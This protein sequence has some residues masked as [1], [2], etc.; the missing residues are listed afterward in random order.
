MPDPRQLLDRFHRTL[1]EEIRATRPEY[2]RLPFTVAEIYQNLIPYRTHRD[3]IGV[4]INGD[5]EDALLRLLVGEGDYLRLESEAA[6]KRIEAE[7]RSPNPNTTIYR[8]FA[9]AEVR[10]NPSRIPA[11]LGNGEGG[12]RVGQEAPPVPRDGG[13]R[14]NPDLGLFVADLFGDGGGRGEP[15]RAPASPREARPSPPAPDALRVAAA[16][17]PPS[18]LPSQGVAS[19]GSGAPAPLPESAPVP[20]EGGVHA[21]PRVTGRTDA[22][23]PPASKG[24]APTPEV[25]RLTEEN[26]RLRRIVADQALELQRLR[27]RLNGP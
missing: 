23:P 21:H 10:L 16:P 24:P 14:V 5:Y 18:T 4:E 15:P 8:E 13:G 20:P 9:A 2:L 7:L 11:D 6:R 26:E 25:A 1:V 22:G 19:P 12:S 17:T 27:E 3:V